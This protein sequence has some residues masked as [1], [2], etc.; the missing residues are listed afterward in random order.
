MESPPQEDWSTRVQGVV[1]DVARACPGQ[2]MALHQGRVVVEDCATVIHE[3]ERHAPAAQLLRDKG[4][5]VLGLPGPHLA[6]ARRR[7]QVE[8]MPRDAHVHRV[9]LE[10]CD[11]RLNVEP[12]RE[13]AQTH[14][15]VADEDAELEDHL[16]QPRRPAREA[17]LQYLCLL[18]AGN[19]EPLATPGCEVLAL[20]QNRGRTPWLHRGLQLVDETCDLAEPV[21]NGR[22]QDLRPYPQPDKLHLQRTNWQSIV[23][24]MKD[25]RLPP[26]TFQPLVVKKHQAEGLCLLVAALREPLVEETVHNARSCHT[27][28][29]PEK[30]GA[31]GGLCQG[32]QVR[33][34]LRGYRIQQRA[35][36]NA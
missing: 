35:V 29:R 34:S 33:N 22:R 18:Q 28:E 4:Q 11:T 26:H 17:L 15:G 5:P 19:L 14:S 12:G 23:E 1:G 32:L 31:A 13:G 27:P 20:C 36:A 6:H 2:A 9:H 24:L 16:V 30:H 3:G 10:R 21:V 25:G 8:H 7:G